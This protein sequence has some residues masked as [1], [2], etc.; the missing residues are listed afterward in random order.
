MNE[1]LLGT[2]RRLR[3]DPS[4]AVGLSRLLFEARFWILVEDPSEDIGAMAFLTYPTEGGVRELPAF[5]SASRTLLRQLR[6]SCEGAASVE[7][8]GEDL[9]P[10]MLDIIRTGDCEVAVDPGEEHGVRITREMIL[11]MVNMYGRKD[12]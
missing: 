8:R 9:W 5:T 1:D 7:V 11:G 3:A 12:P 6:D 2:L 10:R 4:L